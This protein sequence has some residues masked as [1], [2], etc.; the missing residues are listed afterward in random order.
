MTTFQN[1]Y[2]SPTTKDNTESNNS[3]THGEARNPIAEQLNSLSN[4]ES[5]KAQA[6]GNNL[7]QEDNL[8]PT[9]AFR[10]LIDEYQARSKNRKITLPFRQ[11]SG[12]YVTQLY[13]FE[14][15]PGEVTIW[16]GYNGSGK[17]MLTGQIA[18]SIAAQ[19]Q[20]VCI[21]SLEMA[22]E[23]TLMRM[24]RQA[25]KVNTMEF[26]QSQIDQFMTWSNSRIYL[27]DHRGFI[28]QDVILN[29]IS[30]S[31]IDHG[32]KHFFLDSLTLCTNVEDYAN[33]AFFMSQ[34]VD[35]A[36]NLN[37]HIHVITHN[38]KPQTIDTKHFDVYDD[39]N[40]ANIRGSSVIADLAFN[41]FCLSVDLKKQRQRHLGEKVDESTPDLIL[42]LNKHR[43]GFWQGQ[44][45]LWFDPNT[46]NY[47]ETS[48]R[49][50]LDV[51]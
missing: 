49:I 38:R 43:N 17:S 10:Y 39:A 16:S 50:P 4:E 45:K 24:I 19:G 21:A 23:M 29:T 15:R 34:L 41:I 32:C 47:C 30:S 9:G 48:D 12:K 26:T 7:N 42:R 2:M 51:F 36:R 13:P 31:Y 1:P 18:L 44:I 40:Q 3:N 33:Q 37:I 28:T 25:L 27:Y 35:M 20:K 8:A 5:L 46:L 11:Q 6:Y 22:P 14:F